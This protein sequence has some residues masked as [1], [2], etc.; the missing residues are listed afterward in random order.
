MS[1][2]PVI[3]LSLE[4]TGR[5]GGGRSQVIQKCCSFAE[6][7]PDL[8]IAMSISEELEEVY[9]LACFTYFLS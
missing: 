3:N 4:I 8:N 1:F 9:S 2:L 5:E 6:R 7:H